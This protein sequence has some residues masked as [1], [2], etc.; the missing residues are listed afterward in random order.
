MCPCIRPWMLRPGVRRSGRYCTSNGMASNAARY[1]LDLPLAILGRERTGAVV[2]RG[3]QVLAVLPAV[4]V[5]LERRRYARRES[6][7]YR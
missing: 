4:E 1:P 5:I 7:C 3:D 2:N 6:A